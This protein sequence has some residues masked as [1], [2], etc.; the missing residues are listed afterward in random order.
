MVEQFGLDAD[1][2][3]DHVQHCQFGIV[4]G[5]VARQHVDRTLFA[6]QIETMNKFKLGYHV[7]RII[8]SSNEKFI[9]CCAIE[10]RNVLIPSLIFYSNS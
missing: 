1:R 4:D 9:I 7:F 10:V 8:Q 2:L 6:A 3:G 5:L